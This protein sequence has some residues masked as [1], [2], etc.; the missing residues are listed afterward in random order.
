[1]PPYAK[2][3]VPDL[4]WFFRPQ[5]IHRLSTGCP[6]LH[7]RVVVVADHKVSRHPRF[8]RAYLSTYGHPYRRLPWY[9]LL[10]VWLLAAW[11]LVALVVYVVRALVAD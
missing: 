11:G 8:R 3:G 7:R 1:M 2:R 6:Q 9:R 10:T 5:V 4:A